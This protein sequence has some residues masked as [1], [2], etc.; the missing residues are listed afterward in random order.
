MIKKWTSLNTLSDLD[1]MR[2]PQNQSRIEREDGKMTLPATDKKIL[3]ARA[4]NE[5]RRGNYYYY[6]SYAIIEF[7]KGN[8]EYKTYFTEATGVLTKANLAEVY[9]NM[10]KSGSG[11]FDAK[12]AA[13]VVERF[14][15]FLVEY[16]IEDVCGA[17]ELRL[18][19]IQN[20]K[21]GGGSDASYTD[22]LGYYLAQK[23]EIPFL[24]GDIFFKGLPGI[25]F[26]K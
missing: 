15:V 21:P 24:T 19:L 9:Y 22:A 26:V 18:Q 5:P 11:G 7:I 10:R 3:K 2:E 17:M 1:K 13:A 8:K 14:A 4:P 23:M 6:D 25:E 16:D 20:K 12:R